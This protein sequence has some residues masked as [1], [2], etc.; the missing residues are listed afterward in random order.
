MTITII[1][2]KDNHNNKNNNND[3]NNNYS[4]KNNRFLATQDVHSLEEDHNSCP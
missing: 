4:I 3:N 2:S 1:L